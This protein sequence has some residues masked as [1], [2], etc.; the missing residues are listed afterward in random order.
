MMEAPE[1]AEP[2][3]F[4]AGSRQQILTSACYIYIMPCAHSK[5]AAS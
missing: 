3:P 2:P 1:G 5:H 4:K